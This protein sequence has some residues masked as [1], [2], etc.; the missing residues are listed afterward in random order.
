M[1]GF[2]I[3]YVFAELLS[4]NRVV[5]DPSSHCVLSRDFGMEKLGKQLCVY[6]TN[7]TGE[8]LLRNAQSKA[9][10]LN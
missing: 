6:S 5:S 10:S 9:G 1:N 4:S 2:T 7:L 3:Y 8:Y